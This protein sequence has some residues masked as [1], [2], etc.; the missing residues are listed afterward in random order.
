MKK[1]YKGNILPKEIVNEI[2]QSERIILTAH[3]NP[4]GDALG[5]LLAFYF[6]IDEYCKKNNIEKNFQRMEEFDKKLHKKDKTF[7]YTDFVVEKVIKYGN[8]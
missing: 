1:N 3:I 8:N 2:K 5:S 7:F 6:M 4:D